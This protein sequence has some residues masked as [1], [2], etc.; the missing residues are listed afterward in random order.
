MKAQLLKIL[1]CFCLILG[2]FFLQ[3]NLTETKAQFGGSPPN[4][5][6]AP[7]AAPAPTPT[8]SAEVLPPLEDA[9]MII[10]PLVIVT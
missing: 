9:P 6:P 3:F 5:A 10:T 8:A 2:C 4:A 7:V 1:G